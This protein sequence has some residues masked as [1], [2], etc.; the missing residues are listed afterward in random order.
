MSPLF[1]LLSLYFV[2]SGWA[3]PEP[4]AAEYNDMNINQVDAMYSGGDDAM[5]VAETLTLLSRAEEALKSQAKLQGKSVA[6]V[7][8]AMEAQLSATSR[9][10]PATPNPAAEEEGEDE[11]NDDVGDVDDD[12]FATV[13]TRRAGE[14]DEEEE[15][16]VV[17]GA[18]NDRHAVL[19]KDKDGEDQVVVYLHSNAEDA[20]AKH[21]NHLLE[22][23]SQ[24]S[25]GVKTAE[26]LDPRIKEG[27]R[28]AV[29]LSISGFGPAQFAGDILKSSPKKKKVRV[30][31][32]VMQ[33]RKKGERKEKKRGKKKEGFIYIYIYILLLF[34]PVCASTDHNPHRTTA[35]SR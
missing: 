14:D 32:D 33:G 21:A 5:T 17:S 30:W 25:Y 4:R 13:H 18:T 35:S 20:T 26:E 1:F 23:A 27:P 16:Q 24:Y 22:Q 15:G 10:M 11:E 7:R 29:P 8:Q 34:L 9:G 19:E 31:P 3:E 28:T 12:V 2:C 6:E